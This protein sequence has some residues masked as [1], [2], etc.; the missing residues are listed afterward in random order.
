MKIKFNLLFSS[1]LL[2]ATS[3]V[4]NAQNIN[5]SFADFHSIIGIWAMETKK[6]PLFESWEKVNDSTLK[7]RSYK[8]N[9]KDTLILEQVE[10]VKREGKIMYIPIVDENNNRPVV[11]TLIKLEKETYIFENKKHDFPQRIIY[12]LP[13]NNTMHAWIEGDI[14]GQF[15][16]SEYNFVKIY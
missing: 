5:K 4:T 14:N 10:L 13:Q 9:G 1:I 7:S 11:F 3:Y 12:N 15:K 2:F 16:K 8:V 6:G